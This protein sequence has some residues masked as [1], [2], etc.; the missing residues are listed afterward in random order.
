MFSQLIQNLIDHTT[1]PS[2]EYFRAELVLSVTIVLM[3]L[4]RL[5]SVDRFAPASMI[6]ILG[7]VAATWASCYQLYTIHD[8]GGAEFSESFF[9]GMLVQDMFSVYFRIF[10]SLFLVL[11]IALTVLSGIPD[12]EDAPDFYCLLLGATIGM[13]IMASANT[14]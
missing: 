8:M 6:A 11:T 14:C 7:G 3:L 1:G 9:T 10:L 5:F 4:S 2:L 12:N 13:M